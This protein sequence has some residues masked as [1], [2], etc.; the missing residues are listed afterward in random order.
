MK[1]PY[2][3]YLNYGLPSGPINNPGLEAIKSAIN[4]AQ[5]EKK[6][7]YF[8]ADG[9]GGHIFTTTLKEHKRAIRKI[10]NGY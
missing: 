10:R 2:N 3:T 8:V 9:S 1:N 7:Y 4:P 6:Y 5:T